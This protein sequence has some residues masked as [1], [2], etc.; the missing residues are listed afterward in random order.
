MRR[1]ALAVTTAAIL[2]AAG[3]G[4]GAGKLSVGSGATLDLGTGSLDLGCADLTVGGTLSAGTAGFTQA[5]DVT[6][7]PT[8]DS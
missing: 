6:I 5:R 7:D 2:L 8:P 3:S 4:A 1:A